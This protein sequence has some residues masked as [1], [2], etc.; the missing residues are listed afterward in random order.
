AFLNNG[1]V[2]PTL[3]GLL[4]S[5]PTTAFFGPDGSRR[6]DIG[7]TDLGGQ[8]TQPTSAASTPSPPAL[9]W[10]SCRGQ[11]T[12]WDALEEEQNSYQVFGQFNI[13]LGGSHKLHVEAEYAYTDIPFFKSSPSYVTTRPV[14]N[15]VL[16]ANFAGG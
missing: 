11:Y 5:A 10:T 12:R 8:L 3:A 13:G 15:T 16:P 2:T 6:I 4:T 9:P 14:P 1:A 7:C